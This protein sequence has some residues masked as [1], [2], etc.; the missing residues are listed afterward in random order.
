MAADR[1]RRDVRASRMVQSVPSNPG[2]GGTHTRVAHQLPRGEEEK[3]RQS[4]KR[5]LTRAS[6]V[7][8][9]QLRTAPSTPMMIGERQRSVPCASSVTRPIRCVRSRT[10]QRARYSLPT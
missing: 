2:G 8:S 6:G 10:R 5:A 4:E 1:V 7:G 3:R 9:W